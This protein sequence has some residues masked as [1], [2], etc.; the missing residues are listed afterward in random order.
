MIDVSKVGNFQKLR[1]WDAVRGD[2]DVEGR[3]CTVG[4]RKMLFEYD[5]EKRTGRPDLGQNAEEEDHQ[6]PGMIIQNS[7]RR[8]VFAE[9][10][11][12]LVVD[13]RPCC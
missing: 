6:R 2:Y 13:S 12:V 5:C 7:A 11:G 10:P 4:R 9:V 3:L 8:S 1:V